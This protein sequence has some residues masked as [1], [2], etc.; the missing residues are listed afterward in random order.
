LDLQQSRSWR[1]STFLRPDFTSSFSTP[2]DAVV[3]VYINQEK[4]FAFVEM[5]TVEEASN[6]MALDGIVYE[7]LAFLLSA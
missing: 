7:V 1:S 2:G 4:R 6:A 3:N 5:R